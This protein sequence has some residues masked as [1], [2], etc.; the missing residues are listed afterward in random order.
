MLEKVGWVSSSSMSWK[1]GPPVAH[2]LPPIHY[3]YGQPCLVS[4]LSVFLVHT[5]STPRLYLCPQAQ[6]LSLHCHKRDYTDLYP[7]SKNIQHN[8]HKLRSQGR[9]S[10]QQAAQHPRSGHYHGA[11][12][13]THHHTVSL[14]RITATTRYEAC[15]RTWAAS[16]LAAFDF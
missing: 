7:P 4:C 10:K 13:I 16:I 14:S 1:K 6:S 15:M 3:H 11:Y 9:T 2:P 5:P 12:A 8:G